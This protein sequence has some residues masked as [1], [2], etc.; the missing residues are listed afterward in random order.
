ML[1]WLAALLGSS[2]TFALAD[3]ICDVCIEEKTEESA[4]FTED[5]TDDEGG[6]IKGSQSNKGS[7]GQSDDSNSEFSDAPD[8]RDLIRRRE[9]TPQYQKVSLHTPLTAVGTSELSPREPGLTGEQDAA[10]A[11]HNA[12][13]APISPAASAAHPHP[14]RCPLCRHRHHNGALRDGGLLVCDGA[15][16][17]MVRRVTPQV[18]PVHPLAILVRSATC[19]P[20]LCCRVV[21]FS[22]L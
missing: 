15:S 5:G 6:E 13:Q 22:P 11:G 8:M 7:R 10:I 3:V 14:S 19:C 21:A 2:L 20:C 12:P 1:T 9:A 18:E 16:G 4:T 17:W